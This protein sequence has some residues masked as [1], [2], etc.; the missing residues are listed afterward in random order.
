MSLLIVAKQTSIAAVT[1]TAMQLLPYLQSIFARPLISAIFLF[2]AP[3][4]RSLQSAMAR[5]S[6]SAPVDEERA[7]PIGAS[8]LRSACSATRSLC[9]DPHAYWARL[10]KEQPKTAPLQRN[11]CSEVWCVRAAPFL[12][13]GAT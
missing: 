13:R 12:P 9:L 6:R 11:R 4:M 3:S 2:C 5:R 10:P 7:G 1:P 8:T